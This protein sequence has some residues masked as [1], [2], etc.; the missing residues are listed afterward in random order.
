MQKLFDTF[1]YSS[2]RQGE[3]YQDRQHGKGDFSLITCDVR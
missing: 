1:G 2:E 3:H